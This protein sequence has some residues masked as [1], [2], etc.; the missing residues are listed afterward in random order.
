[1]IK[2]HLKIACR[3][4]I[5]GKFYAILNISGLALAIGCCILVYLYT[6]YQLSFDNYHNRANTIYRVVYELHLQKTEYDKGG[7]IAAY[8]ALKSQSTYVKQAAVSVGNQSF[9]VNVN[10]NLN[11]RFR[12]EKNIAFTNSEWFKLFTYSWLNGNAAQL[13]EPNTVALT[14]KQATKYFGNEDPMGRTIQINGQQLKVVG[15]LADSP[16]NTD[17]RSDM[18][19]SFLSVKTLLP[20]IEPAFFTDWGYLMTTNSV[21]VSLED[22]NQKSAVEQQLKQMTKQHLGDGAKYYTFKLLPLSELHF[23]ARYGGKVQKILLVILGAIALLIIII[24]GINYINLVLAGQTRRSIEI[25]T[26]KVLGGSASQLFMQFMVESLLNVIIAVVIAAIGVVLVLPSINNLLFD[27]APIHILSYGKLFLFLGILLL[28]LT[29][30]TGI[31]PAFILSRANIFKALKNTV[32]GL[33]AGYSRKVLVLLQN[34]VAQGLI[35]CTIIIVM[36]VQFLKNTD[37]GFSRKSVI[38]IPIGEADEVKKEQLRQ[39]LASMPGVQSFSFCRRSPSSDSQMGATIKFDNRDWEKWPARF[40]IGDSAYCGT[41]GLQIVAGRN[42]RANPPV[43]EYLINET[44][45]AMLHT[46]SNNDII[47]KK[48]IPGDGPGVIVGIVK[49]FNVRSLLE[50]IE[51]SVLLQNKNQQGN[52]AVKL[53]GQTS[54]ALAELQKTYIRIF[55]D[56]VFTYQFVDDE[57]AGLYKVQILQQKLISGAAFIAIFISSLGLLSLISLITQHRTKEVGIR[58]VLGASIAQISLLLSKDL[59]IMVVTA[60]VIACPIA[61]WLMNKWL[62]G[63]A[64]RITISWWMFAFAAIIA[65]VIALVTVSFQSIKAAIANPVKSLRSV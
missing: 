40:A 10:G 17:L 54:A 5:K 22:E 23:D 13:D 52:L 56:K 14:K 7:S 4:I 45:A 11:K 43:P 42:I 31:Y 36:Q 3:N 65:L 49:D 44:M 39:S 27:N 24:A 28:V 8:T 6:S 34:V 16:F 33:Q 57:I 20:K 9:I 2:H 12:E 38:M 53:S 50:P 19:V 15:L 51:P 29:I 26:R 64:Y 25:G 35:A 18:Y 1:M 63:F 47:G 58:K 62:Q 60:L 61:W 30:A 46:K 48:L 55:P 32:A 21:F 59:L 41:F 37:K